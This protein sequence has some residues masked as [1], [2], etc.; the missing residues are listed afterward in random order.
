M[1]LS[2]F[3]E[4]DEVDDESGGVYEAQRVDDGDDEGQ[5][6]AGLAAMLSGRRAW[7]LLEGTDGVLSDAD[8]E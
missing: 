3:C 7:K 8:I 1:I 2:G 5:N 4:S 6:L